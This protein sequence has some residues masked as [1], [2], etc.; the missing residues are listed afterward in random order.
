MS[1]LFPKAKN[2]TFPPKLIRLLAKL[3]VG[4]IT[5]KPSTKDSWRTR[6]L[7]QEAIARG[8]ALEEFHPLYAGG[9]I[10]IS[11]FRGDEQYFEVLPRPQNANLSALAFMD[12]KAKM[13]EHLSAA[14]IPVARGGVAAR[15]KTALKIFKALTKPVIV[16]P[17]EGSRSRHTTTH[18]TD[19]ANFLEAFRKAK[20]IAPWV[21][22]EEELTGFVFR[23][24]VVHKKLVA[25]LRREPPYVIGNGTASIR[26]LVEEANKNPLRG[27][28][29]FHKILIDIKSTA[30]LTYAGKSWDTIPAK[31]EVVLLGQKTSRAVGGGITDVTDEVHPEN[32]KLLERVAEVLDD[33]LVGVDFIMTNVDTPWQEQPRSGIIEC[34]SAPFIDL[35][36]YPLIGKPRN[37]AGAIWDM[38]YPESKKKE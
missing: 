31:G 38:I 3:R 12:D 11:R 2:T 1:K 34:N 7:W 24:T 8:I 21:I 5:T 9:E 16:K 19:E 23:G 35:H 22:V 37:V 27:G 14:G 17:D 36:H 15:K 29:I 6:V 28:P 20:Q 32:K 13:K 26:S 30:E 18:L 25:V 10:F 33:E 4:N